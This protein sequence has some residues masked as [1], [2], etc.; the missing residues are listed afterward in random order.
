M[1]DSEVQLG[2][3]NEGLGVLGVIGQDVAAELDLTARLV[4][5]LAHLQRLQPGEVVDMGMQQRRRFRQDGGTLGV[6]LVLPGLE[7]GLCRRQHLV[8]LGVA[9]VLETLQPL[10]VV[11][12][13]ALVG[14]EDVS[15]D[16]RSVDQAARAG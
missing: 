6:G 4:N 12:V 2:R 11:G 14:H 1:S 13:D 7:P 16:G 5:A 3:C 8:E 15:L 10:A 9:Q